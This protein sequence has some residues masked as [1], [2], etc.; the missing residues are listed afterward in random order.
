MIPAIISRFTNTKCIIEG[1]LLETIQIIHEKFGHLAD[2]E[3]SYT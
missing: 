1:R 3:L 2:A